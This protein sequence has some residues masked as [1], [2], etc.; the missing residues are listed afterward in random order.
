MGIFNKG[1]FNMRKVLCTAFI[2]ALSTGVAQAAQ[3]GGDDNVGCGWG[4]MLF[5]GQSGL[6]P[7][8]M[9]ATT[10]GTFGNQ[11][12]GITSGTAGCTQ[13]G[14]VKGSRMVSMFM[15]SN[16]D[17]LASDMSV[18]EG[19]T[20]ETLASLMGIAEQDKPAFFAAARDNFTTIFPSE[21]ATAE[22]VYAAL[23]KVMAA[24]T[25]LAPYVA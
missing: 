11:T 22:E 17:K 4:S 23:R 1:I 3:H 12:F 24:D 21:S 7:Q 8:V 15:G 9:A 18:G 2:A 25:T 14:V 10:N 13:D 19:E 20:L 6:A 16:L 5:D